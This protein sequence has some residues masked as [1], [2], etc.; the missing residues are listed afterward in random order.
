M[1]YAWKKKL[2]VNHEVHAKISFYSLISNRI[3]STYG[4]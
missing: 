1:S 4:G 2:T 3:I